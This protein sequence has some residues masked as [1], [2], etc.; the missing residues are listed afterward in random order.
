MSELIISDIHKQGETIKRE[1]DE[2]CEHFVM[3]C[4][5]IRTTNKTILQETEDKLQSTLS[6]I[7]DIIAKSKAAFTS[8]SKTGATHLKNRLKFQIDRPFEK[9]P[10]LQAQS[11]APFERSTGQ[12]QTAGII[13]SIT[14]KTWILEEPPTAGDTNH[15]LGALSPISRATELLSV[16]VTAS[17]RYCVD[18]EIESVFPGF[19]GRSW[20]VCASS[21]EARLVDHAGEYDPRRSITLEKYIYINDLVSTKDKTRTLVCCSDQSVR[22]VHHSNGHCDVMFRTCYYATSLCEARDAGCVIVSHYHDGKLI[23]YNQNGRVLQTIDK[24]NEGKRLFHSPTSVRVNYSNGDIVVIESSCPRHVVVVDRKLEVLC[25]YG[26]YGLPESADDRK[27]SEFMP[28]D[29]CFD[30]HDNIVISDSGNKTIVLADRHG[31]RTKM[32][33]TCVLEPRRLGVEPAGQVWIG[34]QDGTV[35]II[36]Y[37]LPKRGEKTR[38]VLQ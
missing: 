35:K 22:Q 29:V 16:K 18:K 1:V 21:T 7:K 37:K 20:L 15:F 13:G 17:F 3:Q 19:D 9:L 32:L 23:K 27:T 10:D 34:F 31:N 28:S 30:K 26:G 4:K 38:D 12:E 36:K 25:R 5:S 6:E 24:D 11:F 33:M 14:S 8:G 2:T